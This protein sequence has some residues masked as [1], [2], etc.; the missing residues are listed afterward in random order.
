VD[1]DAYVWGRVEPYVAP[2]DALAAVLSTTPGAPSTTTV[3]DDVVRIKAERGLVI[4]C[5]L[6][7][8][9]LTRD[10]KVQIKGNDITSRARNK[11]RIRG[12][13]IDLN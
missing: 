5:G 2:R 7:T 10:G 3:E 4:E 9:I 12:A 11:N 13:S 1:G 6:S 8:L